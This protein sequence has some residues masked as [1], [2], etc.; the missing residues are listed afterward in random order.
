MTDDAA[1]LARGTVSARLHDHGCHDIAAD[2]ARP[3]GREQAARTQ[4]LKAWAHFARTG[5]WRH[6]GWHAGGSGDGGGGGSS[7]GVGGHGQLA[8]PCHLPP[9]G[10]P[11]SFLKK[12]QRHLLRQMQTHAA[13]ELPRSPIHSL[14][15]SRPTTLRHRRLA[16]IDPVRLQPES[17]AVKCICHPKS[18]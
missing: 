7:G 3:I 5:R 2:N 14:Q 13:Q 4:F 8:L 18:L 10:V 17:F 11:H 9:N 12:T 16:A 1:R 15:A 6:R